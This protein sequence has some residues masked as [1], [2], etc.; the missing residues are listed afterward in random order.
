MSSM[1]MS[2]ICMCIVMQISIVLFSYKIGFSL[3]KQSQR[4]RSILQDGSRYLGLLGSRSFGLFGRRKKNFYKRK[5]GVSGPLQVNKYF[6]GYANTVKPACVVT[7][8]TGS[9]VLSGLMRGLNS[10]NGV[11]QHMFLFRN[12][13]NDP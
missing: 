4:S 3:P 9:P 7:S 13:K 1:T 5:N 2:Y 12:K 10:S 11:S 6:A 8:I